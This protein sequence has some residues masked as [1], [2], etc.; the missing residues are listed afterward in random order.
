MSDEGT[1]AEL[2]ALLAS[3]HEAVGHVHRYVSE[4]RPKLDGSGLYD[5]PVAWRRHKSGA[6]AYADHHPQ[7]ADMARRH[8][9]EPLFVAPD[10]DD[11]DPAA[12]GT[13]G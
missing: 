3:A 12:V 11:D 1:H 7:K 13:A 6:W 5:V 4:R 9:W 8:G 10:P 2:L